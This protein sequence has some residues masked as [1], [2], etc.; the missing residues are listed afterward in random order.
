MNSILAE[1]LWSVVSHFFI[2]EKT[3]PGRPE[4]DPKKAFMGVW[5]VMENGIKWKYLPSEF[6]KPSTV[7]AKMMRWIKKGLCK[8]VFELMRKL[9]LEKSTAFKNWF[10]VDTSHSKASFAK[11]GGKSPVDRSKRGIKKNIATDSHGT[12]LALAVAPGNRHDAETLEDLLPQLKQIQQAPITIIAADAAYQSQKLRNICLQ[13]NFLLHHATKK[14][15]N[16]TTPRITPNGRWIVEAAHSWINNFRSI[17][18][19]FSKLPESLLFFLRLAS[20]SLM[21]RRI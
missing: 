20:S 14:F 15:K 6:G 11:N 5:Y 4:H 3:S 18:T 2:K 10:V 9:Y 8:K 12:I 19:C 7:H 13:D 17:R 16:S 21:L 1:K